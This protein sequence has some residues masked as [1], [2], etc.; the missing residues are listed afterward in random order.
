MPCSIKQ[1]PFTSHKLKRLIS[2]RSTELAELSFGTS[3]L[4]S[5]YID[6]HLFIIKAYLSSNCETF[7]S[8]ILVPPDVILI[9]LPVKHNAIIVRHALVRARSYC[10]SRFKKLEIEA[11]FWE[12]ITHREGRFIKQ[13]W[14]G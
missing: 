14:C 11:C 6:V 12:I 10:F 4:D 1:N 5:I 13:I 9:I 7:G 8:R 2:T 3:F